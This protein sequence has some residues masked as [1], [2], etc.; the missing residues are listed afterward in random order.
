MNDYPERRV[1]RRVPFN[2]LIAAKVVGTNDS[3]FLDDASLGGFAIRSE[4]PFVAGSL[5]RFR[6]QNTAGQSTVVQAV[7]RYCVRATFERDHRVG[8]EFV[9]HE[10]GRLQLVIDAM[11]EMDI[12]ATSPLLPCV[13]CGRLMRLTLSSGP[14]GDERDEISPETQ[15]Q[16]WACP[17][18]Q[19]HNDRVFAGW[20]LAADR[21]RY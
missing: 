11:N 17:W 5:Y 7:C 20:L 16:K 15:P 4:K 2:R 18:C 1:T 21:H 9:L 12:S 19:K 3:F 8:F 14:L 6:L 13:H 10:H